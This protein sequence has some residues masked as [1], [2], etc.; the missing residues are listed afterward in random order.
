VGL[1]PLR[2]WDDALAEALTGTGL[3]DRADRTGTR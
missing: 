2:R 1:P 3:L